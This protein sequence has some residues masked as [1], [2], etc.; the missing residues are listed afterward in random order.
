MAGALADPVLEL[1]EPDGTIVTNDNWKS[2]QQTEIEA[3]GL[4]PS[5]DLESAI[6]ATLPEGLYTA[7]VSGK[8]NG[9]GVGLVEVYDLDDPAATTYLGNISTRGFVQTAEK[10]MIGGFIIGEGVQ[11]GQVVVRAIGP[12]LTS[13]PDAL[14]DPTLSLYD[15]Q[16]MVVAVNDDWE[17]ANK[18]AIEATGLAPSD[19]RESAILA[20]LVPGAYTAIVE[21][22]GGTSGIGLVEVYYIP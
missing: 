15:A 17:E 9:T 19:L 13:I 22:T 20:D 8:D 12:S 14:Q 3:T 21:G 18:D 7:I 11:T 2:N 16:G 1:H 6:I 4:A 10:A 5:N